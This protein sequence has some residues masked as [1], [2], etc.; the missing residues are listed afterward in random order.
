MELREVILAV[1]EKN[2]TKTQLENYR[3]DLANIFAEMQ[4]ELAEIRKAKALYWL[5]DKKETDIATE[6][7]WA[8]T[9]QGQ[10]EIE[11]SHYAKATEKILSS[12][13]SRLYSVY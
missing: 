2:L 13:K 6:R 10:R 4:F 11:L 1:K 8:V 7:A 9:K 12:L 5:S 3:D